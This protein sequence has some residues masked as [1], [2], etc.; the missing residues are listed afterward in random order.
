MGLCWR[1]QLEFII[2][3]LVLCR[4]VRSVQARDNKVLAIH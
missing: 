3:V 4:D 1:L 2:I